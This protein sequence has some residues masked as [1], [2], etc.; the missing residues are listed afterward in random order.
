MADPIN[1]RTGN[2]SLQQLD[3]QVKT[4][5]RPLRFERSYNAL[6]AGQERYMGFGWTHN[7]AMG[8]A[9]Q[10][11][12]PEVNADRCQFSHGM[13]IV[14]CTTA[15]SDDQARELLRLLGFPF[16]NLPVVV[17]GQES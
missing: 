2:F 15:R 4:R 17:L 10:I 13:N 11:V 12:F 9:D 16:R 7:Y 1:F 3:H 5:G 8:L 6:A 14:V